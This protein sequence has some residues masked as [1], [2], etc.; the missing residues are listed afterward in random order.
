MF[1]V[2]EWTTKMKLVH[3]DGG[4]F[5]FAKLNESQTRPDP[6]ITEAQLTARFPQADGRPTWRITVTRPMVH[7]SQPSCTVRCF[8]SEYAEPSNLKICGR[9]LFGKPAREIETPAVDSGVGPVEFAPRVQ[10]YRHAQKTY[11]QM[12]ALR[13]CSVRSKIIVQVTKVARR[14]VSTDMLGEENKGALTCVLLHGSGR[15]VAPR[16]TAYA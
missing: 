3:S 7:I 16:V 8:V 9:R 10:L 2:P 15:L 14:L 11:K 1:L 5:T 13:Q 4:H 12:Q 6:D